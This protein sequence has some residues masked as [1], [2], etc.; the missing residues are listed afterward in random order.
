M[1]FVPFT[2]LKPCYVVINLNIHCCFSLRVEDNYEVQKVGCFWNLNVKDDEWRIALLLLWG[3]KRN[4]GE[5]QSILRM[6]FTL[7]SLP[8]PILNWSQSV[9]DQ[10]NCCDECGMDGFCMEAYNFF[11]FY[12]HSITGW[13]VTPIRRN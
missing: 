4:C 1:T 12:L 5:S 6:F 3:S 13:N 9:L 8:K 10:P 11:F 7:Q 2:F